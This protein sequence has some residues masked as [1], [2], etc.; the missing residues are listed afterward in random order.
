MP[1]HPTPPSA[2]ARLNALAEADRRRARE[3][4]WAARYR[5]LVEAAAIA[6]DALSP[7]GRRTL[8][9]LAE[10]DEPTIEGLVEILGA[11]RTAAQMANHRDR[12]GAC[13]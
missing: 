9:W 8:D 12:W 1:D 10:W 11:V 3:A 7:K 13:R 2:I 5:R 4:H 6:P